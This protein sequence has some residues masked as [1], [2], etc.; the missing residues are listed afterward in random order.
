MPHRTMVYAV[1]AERRLIAVT[2]DR[3]FML[4]D[5]DSGPAEVGDTLSADDTRQIWF[6]SS[7]RVRLVAY[8]RQRGI[9]PA[10]LH[11][12]LYAKSGSG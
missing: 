8:E 1:N 4:L 11:K 9:R 6:N 12:C 2:E 5:L 10:E 3:G 7:R